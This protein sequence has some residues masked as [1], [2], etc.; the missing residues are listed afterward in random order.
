MKIL[1]PR[2]RFM[3][4]GLLALASFVLG[5]NGF[6]SGTLLPLIVEDI[7]M[8]PLQSGIL[9]ATRSLVMGFLSIPFSNIFYWPKYK[10]KR[11]ISI[12][13][14]VVALSLI[15]QALAPTYAVMLIFRLTGSIFAVLAT[16]FWVAIRMRWFPKKEYGT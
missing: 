1:W 14:F 13:Q 11:I 9:G 4:L 5:I 16:A 2:Y 7:G 15:G 3:I 6:V 12:S 10:A 8:T